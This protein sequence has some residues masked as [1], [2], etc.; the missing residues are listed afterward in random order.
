LTLR[1][2]GIFDRKKST[3]PSLGTAKPYCRFEAA[4]PLDLGSKGK[5]ESKPV[6]CFADVD[7]IGADNNALGVVGA[8]LNQIDMESSCEVFPKS[9]GLS[10]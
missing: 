7:G 2:G 8:R 5:E 10:V 1:T 4:V 3:Y 9:F 6:F